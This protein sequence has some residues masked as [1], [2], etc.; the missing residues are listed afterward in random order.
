MEIHADIQIPDNSS[1]SQNMN[2]SK[3]TAVESKIENSVSESSRKRC[4]L[5]DFAFGNRHDKFTMCGFFA[6]LA[7]KQN[8]LDF[9]L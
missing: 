6:K 3:T 1:T 5:P 9:S 8:S 4:A 2:G 7:L